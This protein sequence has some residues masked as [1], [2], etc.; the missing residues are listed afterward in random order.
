MLWQFPAGIIKP[1]ASPE[2][3]AVEETVAETGVY[4]RVRDWLGSR[5]HPI[6]NVVCDYLLCEYLSG[7]TRNA[8]VLENTDVRWVDRSDLA[9]FIL[10]SQIYPPVI[11]ALAQ[12]SS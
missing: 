8:D 12:P 5:L 11:D 6:T 4:S 1:G 10:P 7:E 9:H 3:V 2:V